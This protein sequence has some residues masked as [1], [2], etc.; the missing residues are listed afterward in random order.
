[1]P[2]YTTIRQTTKGLKLQGREEEGYYPIQN[3]R[4]TLPLIEMI[5]SLRI[6]L[7]IVRI[8]PRAPHQTEKTTLVWS[9]LLIQI[10]LKIWLMPT[11]Q[12]PRQKFHLEEESERVRLHLISVFAY[13]K[14]GHPIQPFRKSHRPILKLPE[15]S[16]GGFL[17]PVGE[18]TLGL[19]LFSQH[20]WKLLFL[21]ILKPIY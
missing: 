16:M 21:P 19:N 1:M 18:D 7:S 14:I 2:F 9:L 4:W 11:A 15:P 5:F 6:K 13:S 20:V 17:L 8:F 3:L 10:A 12:S